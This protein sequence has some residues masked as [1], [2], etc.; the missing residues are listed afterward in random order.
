MLISEFRGADMCQFVNLSQIGISQEQNCWN[1]L[2]YLKFVKQVR[3]TCHMKPSHHIDW[4]LYEKFCSFKNQS[5][6]PEIL[7]G[8]EGIL[9]APCCHCTCVSGSFKVHVWT[10][11]CQIFWQQGETPPSWHHRQEKY[12][13][14]SGLRLCEAFLHT[15]FTLMLK[16]GLSEQ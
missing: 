14:L 13:L 11:P 5:T 7:T 4:C 6:L 1:D 10:Q 2:N 12:Q 3:Q 8:S 15:Y 16:Q 9:W